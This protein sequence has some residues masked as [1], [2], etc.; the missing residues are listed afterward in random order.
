MGT[1]DAPRR[2]SGRTGAAG[3]AGPAA[4]FPP[5][6]RPGPASAPRRRSHSSPARASAGRSRAE[7]APSGKVVGRRAARG[8]TPPRSLQ[9]GA[10]R[11]PGPTEEVAARGRVP[12]SRGPAPRGHRR[13]GRRDDR[14]G[15]A[16]G[17]CPATAAGRR[18]GREAHRARPGRW[19][20][21]GPI[22]PVLKHGPRSLARARVFERRKLQGATKVR[23]AQPGPPRRDPPSSGGASPAGPGRAQPSGPG[24]VGAH[25]LGPERR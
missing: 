13:A 4:G 14:R 3:D 1:A 7:R 11:G 17:Q 10:P 24:R 12:P 19:R 8:R 6:D 20:P 16:A 15:T 5:G 9:P 18:G 2:G 22:R 25:A 21:D 23:A